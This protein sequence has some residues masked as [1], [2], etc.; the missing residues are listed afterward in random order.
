M[1]VLLSVALCGSLC[2]G[3]L[4]MAQDDPV[5]RFLALVNQARLDE[6]LP[7]YAWSSRLASAAQ[8]HADDLA[9]HGLASH[10]GS[11]GSTPAQRVAAADY[12]AWGNGTVVGE[13]FW[14]GRG[15]VEDALAWFMQDPPHRE[16]LLS[17]RYREIGIGIATDAEGQQYYV[18]D[19]GARPNVLPVL[20]NDGAQTA[21]SPDVTLTL[22]NEEAYPQGEGLAY[23]GRAIEVRISNTP[24]MDDL[25]WRPWEP[26]LEWLLPP[27]P[28]DHTVYVAF[29]DGAGRTAYATATIFLLP[30]EGTPFPTPTAAEESTPTATAAPG[31]TPSPES[32]PPGGQPPPGPTTAPATATRAPFATWTPLPVPAP[33]VIRDP[34]LAWLGV[35]CGLQAVVLLLGAYVT[36]RRRP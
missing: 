31:A 2:L 6:G 29:R 20:I 16:N 3:A 8:R 11:D 15:E 12:F 36:L 28:G 30:G 7:P 14:V 23:M 25:P 17:S 27:E 32:P 33:A 18:L 19:F 1:Y 35:V 13:N 5:A 26:Q 21:E 9:A 34:Q 22:T 4:T 24:E 10:V